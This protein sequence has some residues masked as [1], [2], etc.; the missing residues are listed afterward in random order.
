[1]LIIFRYKS[2]SGSPHFADDGVGL[3]GVEV[4][5]KVEVNLKWDEVRLG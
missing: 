2:I 1:M 4:R 5:V 3:S